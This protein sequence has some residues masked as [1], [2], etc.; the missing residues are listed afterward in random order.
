[1]FETLRTLGELE[2]AAPDAAAARRVAE[3]VFGDKRPAG[4]D[5]IF[6]ATAADADGLR[7]LLTAA[8]MPPPAEPP[9]N[10]AGDRVRALRENTPAA[11]HRRATAVLLDAVGRARPATDEAARV[12][13]EAA[14]SDDPAVRAAAV[15]ALAGTGE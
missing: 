6:A 8:A 13:L 5:A 14:G 7:T 9:G 11:R 12:L 4:V 2:A 1:M 15:E 10:D 3:F